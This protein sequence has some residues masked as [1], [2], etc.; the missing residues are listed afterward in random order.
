M[1]LKVAVIFVQDGT[2]KQHAAAGKG[3]CSYSINK[4]Y[5]LLVVCFHT[6]HSL[7][8]KQRKPC[9]ATTFVR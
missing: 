5:H 3:V 8:H 9:S 4:P 7:S 1:A 2:L 6:L